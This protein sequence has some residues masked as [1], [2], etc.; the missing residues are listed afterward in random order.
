MPDE[1]DAFLVV[2]LKMISYIVILTRING[3]ND[4]KENSLGCI[5]LNLQ[6]STV[7]CVCV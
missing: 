5:F 4:K 1:T 7:L 6:C 3:I 2:V